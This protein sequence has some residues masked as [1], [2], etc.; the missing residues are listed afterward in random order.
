LHQ[1]KGNILFAGGQVEEWNN[2]AL[3]GAASQ[4]AG[5]DLFMPTVLPGPNAPAPATAVY[6]NNSGAN[7]GVE[8]SPPPSAAPASSLATPT[9]TPENPAN[10]SPGSQGRFSQKTPGQPR[11]QSL[12]PAAKTNPSDSISTN[13]S[14]GG[15]ATPA[16][17]D[18][19]TTTFDQRL[20][21]ILRRVIFGTYLLVLLIF[22]LLL[23]FKSRQRA[24]RKQERRKTGL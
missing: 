16:E 10:E 24:R 21:K 9:A 4:Q 19:A 20:V 14:A 5:A 12:P 23:A 11:P 22:L 8:T 18:S 1:F 13:A 2:A 17:L 3:V 6:R 15:T 7:P